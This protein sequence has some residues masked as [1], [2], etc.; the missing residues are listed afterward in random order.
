MRAREYMVAPGVSLYM[1]KA[2]QHLKSADAVLARIIDS[3]G[4]CRMQY[5]EPDFGT[6]ARSIVYQ[7]LSG[8]VA[9]V[10]FGRVA[11]ITGE[12]L[13][14]AAILRLTPEQLRSAGL[15]KQK[16]D[17]LRDLAARSRAIGFGRL[18]SLPDQEVIERL[19]QVK[20]VGV[21]TAHMFL[22]FALRRP[23]VL[24]VGDLGIRSAIRKAY[25]FPEMPSAKQIEQ[26]AEPWHP[27]C[28]VASWYLWRS[29]E[30][31]AP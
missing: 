4:P 28:T 5:M 8:K 6:L 22:M 27:W 29:L 9:A 2:V 13:R 14:P 17:Y 24:P 3:V 10:I 7:Q 19:T 20:G 23:D 21:W 15:S 1:R 30:N 26:I 25:G 18:S 12:P 31:A 11:A 16:T